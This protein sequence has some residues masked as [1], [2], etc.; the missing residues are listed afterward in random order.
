MATVPFAMRIDDVFSMKA[1]GQ[2][3]QIVVTGV[4][5]SGAIRVGDELLLK[6]ARGAIQ[7]TAI[8]IESF[9]NPARPEAEPIGIMVRG[10]ARSDITIGD[11]LVSPGTEA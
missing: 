3:E 7:V 2:P 4:P 10:A 6:T 1:P 9:I 8:A 5:A 11:E